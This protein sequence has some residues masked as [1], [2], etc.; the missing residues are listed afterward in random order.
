MR[1]A[2]LYPDEVYGRTFMDLFWTELQQYG[3]QVVGVEAYD[4]SKTDFS[5]PIRK[6]VGLYYP[7]PQDLIASRPKGQRTESHRRRGRA[8]NDTNDD[9]EDEEL[10]AIVDFDAI[11]IP[12]SPKMAGLLIPQLAFHDVRGVVLIGTNLWHSKT[13]L[14]LAGQYVQGAILPDG[15]FADSAS[16][17]VQAFVQR[18]EQTFEEKPGYIEAILY[19]SAM[20]LFDV[21]RRP[22][23]QF[24]SDILTALTDANGFGG[25]TGL[26]RFSED[27]EVVK[28]AFLLRVEGDEFIE[29]D[30]R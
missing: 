28:Q 5:D 22:E 4:P 18:F 25:V 7:V 27:G 19:D 29:L 24:R 23:V 1:Y 21:V 6:L 16:T 15:F 30:R 3:G 10:E 11:F 20:I 13:L 9:E 12:E 8:G 17:G 26:T 2:I 14:D